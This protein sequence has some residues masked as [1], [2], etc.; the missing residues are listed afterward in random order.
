MPTGIQFAKTS[1]REEIMNRIFYLIPVVIVLTIFACTDTMTKL[2]EDDTAPAAVGNLLVLESGADFV[3]LIW[4]VPEN[5]DIANYIV[6]IDD[7]LYKD[8]VPANSRNLKQG[9][10]IK[11]LVPLTDY[12]FTVSVEDTSG[13]ESETAE[14]SV[15]T[16]DANP[17]DDTSPNS[18]TD[19]KVTNLF[20]LM[21][22]D[23]TD[24]GFL[25]LEFTAPGDD[26]DTGLA[27]IEV[28]WADVQEWGTTLIYPAAGEYYCGIAGESTE[29]FV[30]FEP[31]GTPDYSFNIAVKVFDEAGNEADEIAV[32]S[33]K[34]DVFVIP[35]KCI[36]CWDCIEVCPEDPKAI[37]K[38]N[39]KAVIDLSKC[40][41]CGECVFE[42]ETSE[43]ANKAIK[44]YIYE[45]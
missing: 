34:Q 14:L 29:L 4:N 26:G 25:K 41:R 17:A 36:G 12:V 21:T 28:W 3:K 37:S 19:L 6:Y 15:T 22:P 44:S 13:N 20:S 27:E 1:R 11:E 39:G 45:N 24:K 9:V 43:N 40:T 5:D 7:E 31:Q 8:N 32:A 16:I 10:V 38:V 42:C 33:G 18:I 2:T 23:T 35:S 30:P